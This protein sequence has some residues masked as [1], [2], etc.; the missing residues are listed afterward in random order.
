[1]S[2]NI[3]KCIANNNYKDILLALGEGAATG[4][5]GIVGVP[6]NITLSLFLFFRAV[7][8][9]ALYYGYDVNDDPRELE[10]ASSVVMACISPNAEKGT[11]TLGGII[12]QMMLVANFETLKSSLGKKTFQQMAESGGIEL[13]YTQIRALAN[14]A[15]Q[16]ALDKAGKDGLEQSVFKELLKQL[17]ERLPKEAAKKSIPFISAAIG[18]LA[19]TYQ[20]SRILKGANLIYH[21]RFLL[22]KEKRNVLLED[23]QDN[24]DIKNC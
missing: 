12:G 3:E 17:G 5:P 6:F 22:E 10:F 14:K 19:D 18:G 16:K 20:M 7:Q 23:L 24:E 13:I 4:F 8:N 21:K 2:Y 15:A 9:I 11:E 1:R